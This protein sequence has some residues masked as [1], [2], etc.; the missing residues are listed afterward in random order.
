MSDSSARRV[1]QGSR[2][3][4]KP[5]RACVA[6]RGLCAVEEARWPVFCRSGAKPV[7]TECPLGLG[8]GRSHEGSVLFSDLHLV[9]TGRPGLSLALC[10]ST[11]HSGTTRPGEFV[12][13]KFKN[14]SK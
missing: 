10:T 9:S 12:S 3:K 13:L 2:W 11:G 6:T 1:D 7:L 5:G 4:R 8:A 14:G